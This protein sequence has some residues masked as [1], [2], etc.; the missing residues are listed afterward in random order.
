MSDNTAVRPHSMVVFAEAPVEE[1]PGATIRRARGQNF[2][3]DWI[4]ATGTAE[5]LIESEAEGMLLLPGPGATIKG[6]AGAVAAPGRSVCLLP[7]GRHGVT[8]A[9]RGM[10]VLLRS[11]APVTFSTITDW[12]SAACI[13]PA[14]S[15]AR[16]SEVPPGA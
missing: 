7:P 16:M 9:G 8:P 13:G 3:V 15:R 4:D 11:A 5:I 10:M 6:A 1:V 2:L 14:S 12:P